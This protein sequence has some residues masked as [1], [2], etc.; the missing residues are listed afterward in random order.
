MSKEIKK[1][2]KPEEKDNES[3]D[4]LEKSAIDDVKAVQADEKKEDDPVKET[5]PAEKEDTPVADGEFFKL[6][7]VDRCKKDPVIPVT[8]LLAFVAIIVAFLYFLIPNLRT[9][10][11]GFTLNEFEERYNSG[12]VA[13]QLYSN[14][15]D[16]GINYSGYV[17]PSASTGILGEKETFKAESSDVDYFSGD[18]SLILNAGLEGATR[19][20]DNELAYVRVYVEYNEEQIE[21]VWMIFANTLQAL[22]PELSRFE[23][24]DLALSEMNQFKGDGMFAVR[25]DIAFRIMQNRWRIPFENIVYIGDN[26]SKD[27]Q[28]PLQLGMHFIYFENSDGIYPRKGSVLEVKTIKDLKELYGELLNE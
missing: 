2:V 24:L 19:K 27:L 3:F 6:G 12:E 23:C 1:G 4:E 13:A 7:F 26:I 18:I 9:P 11:L 21:P 14:G 20:K 22:Y 16:I 5:D 17:D 10:S 25:G 8:I 28:A 15:M